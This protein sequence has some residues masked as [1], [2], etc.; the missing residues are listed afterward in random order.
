MKNAAPDIWETCPMVGNSF[1]FKFAIKWRRLRE[2]KT[3]NRRTE[4]RLLRSH[5]PVRKTPLEFVF[6]SLRSHP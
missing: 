4:T 3:K 2:A 6:L 1:R 5:S